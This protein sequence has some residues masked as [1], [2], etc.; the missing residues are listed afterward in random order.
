MSSPAGRKRAG[1]VGIYCSN[2]AV[3]DAGIPWESTEKSRVGVYVGVT[4]HGNVETENPPA[5]RPERRLTATMRIQQS[6]ALN[7]PAR[8]R[9]SKCRL[10]AEIWRR[11]S[12]W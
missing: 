11:V 6:A 7:A 3:K 12:G 5:E 4:E 9:S 1:S 8:S 2:E 10:S